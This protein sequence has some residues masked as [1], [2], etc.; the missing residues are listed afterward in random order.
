MLSLV[1]I[2]GCGAFDRGPAATVER[3]YRLVER[4]D[5][6]EAMTLLS[7]SLTAMMGDKMRIGL[8]EQSRGIQAKRGIRSFNVIEE[9][10]Q[11][12]TARVVM[13]VIYGDGSRQREAAALVKEDGA[14][15][16]TADK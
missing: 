12:Q 14:W 13:E 6:S 4:G 8:A 7:G 11:G 16:I 2:S 10:V 9:N 15:R 5:I 3:F 1:V